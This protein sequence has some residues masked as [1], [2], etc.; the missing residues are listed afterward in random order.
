VQHITDDIQRIR[1]T[2]VLANLSICIL[3]FYKAQVTKFKAACFNALNVTILDGNEIISPISTKTVD[4]AQ[5]TEYDIV[6]LSLV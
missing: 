2:P 4:S 5:G 6:L 1:P 3:S